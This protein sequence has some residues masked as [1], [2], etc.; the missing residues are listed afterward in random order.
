MTHS[1]H[2][3]Y[4]S[5]PRILGLREICSIH[6]LGARSDFSCCWRNPKSKAHYSAGSQTGLLSPLRLLHPGRLLRGHYLQFKRQPSAE[7]SKT[8]GC[9]RGCLTMGDWDPKSRHRGFTISHQRRHPGVRLER[10]QRVS[11][12]LF[13]ITVLP[14]ARRTG[15][16]DLR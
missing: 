2:R 4:G 5:L 13:S 1:D 3:R 6:Y 12:R 10:R 8:W 15:S 11:V 14:C 7:R 16:Q 9:R